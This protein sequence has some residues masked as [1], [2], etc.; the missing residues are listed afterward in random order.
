MALKDSALNLKNADKGTTVIMNKTEKMEEAKV[1]FD[2]RLH[3]KPL[4]SP[5]VKNTQKRVN[6]IIDQMHRGKH[7]N[8][9]TRKWLSQTLDP[10]RT[11]IFHKLSKIHKPIPVGRHIISGCYGP[12]ERISSFVEILL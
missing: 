11:P 12:T 6:E 8:D 9:I 4:R 10:P 3:N 2:N 1:Q 5:I 7:I